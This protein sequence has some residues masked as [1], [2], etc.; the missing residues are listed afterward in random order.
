MSNGPIN[1]TRN[2]QG[3]GLEGSLGLGRIRVSAGNIISVSSIQMFSRYKMNT[4]EESDSTKKEM[5]PL[6]PGRG[7]PNL[8]LVVLGKH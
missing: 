4:P 8:Y 5:V 3:L 7:T 2:V 6:S 1:L